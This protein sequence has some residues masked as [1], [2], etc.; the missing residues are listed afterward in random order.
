MTKKAS[1]AVVEISLRHG[2]RRAKHSS[3]F[4][5]HRV[6]CLK[7]AGFPELFTAA[8]Q[9]GNQQLESHSQKRFLRFPDFHSP[10]YYYDDVPMILLRIG[11]SRKER[12]STPETS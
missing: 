12:P 1:G 3:E 10:Y 11:V 4:H 6:S 8:W 9:H 5:S 2:E 7:P